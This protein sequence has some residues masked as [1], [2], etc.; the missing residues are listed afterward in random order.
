MSLLLRQKIALILF[1]AVTGLLV[2][3]SV[4]LNEDSFEDASSIIYAIKTDIGNMREGPGKSYKV[5]KQLNEG[6]VFRAKKIESGWV[7]GHY[8]FVNGWIHR[9]ILGKYL[10]LKYYG[11]KVVNESVF[12]IGR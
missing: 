4:E 7:K 3:K 10:Y 8:Q 2:F 5:I 12:E 1:M 6:A 9:S 11:D